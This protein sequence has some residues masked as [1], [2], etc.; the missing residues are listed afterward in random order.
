MLNWNVIKKFFAKQEELT[1]EEEAMLNA[2][3]AKNTD[4]ASPALATQNAGGSEVS[5]LKA[6]IEKSRQETESLRKL[7]EE[8]RTEKAKRDNEVKEQM[9]RELE[10]KKAAA[11]EKLVKSSILAPADEEGK[12]SWGALLDADY[13]TASKL[14]DKQIESVKQMSAAQESAATGSPPSSQAEKAVNRTDLINQA[15]NAFKVLK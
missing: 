12:K 6:I 10:G 3:F 14:I 13:E 9:K 7:I 2:E 1:A 8:E 4:A 11:L 5:L 15:K